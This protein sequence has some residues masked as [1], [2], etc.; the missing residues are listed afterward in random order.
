MAELVIEKGTKE[1]APTQKGEVKR[2]GVEFE[3][4][5]D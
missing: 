1:V 2:G 5:F 3:R 4:M